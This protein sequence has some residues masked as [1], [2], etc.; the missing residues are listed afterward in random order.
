MTDSKEKIILVTRNFPPLEGGMERLN[1]RLFSAMS[2]QWQMLLI[3]PKNASRFLTED[4]TVSESRVRPLWWFMLS[5][6][7]RCLA[8][9]IRVKP[10]LIVAGSG[11]MAPAA[12]FAAKFSHSKTVVYLHGLDLVVQNRVYQYCW[13][14]LIRRCDHILVNSQSTAKIAIEKGVRADK[15]NL[16]PPGT[17]IPVLSDE[18]AKNFRTSLGLQDAVILLTVGRLT[19]RKGIAEFVGACLPEIVSV[20][21]NAVLLIIG[22][23]ASNALAGSGVNEKN[24]IQLQ[25]N[26][27][28]VADN[29]V[30]LGRCDDEMLSAAYQAADMHVFPVQQLPGDVEGFGMVAV[31]AAAHGLQTV[32]FAVGGV[33]ESVENGTSGDLIATGD[34]DQF[35]KRILSRLAKADSE[36]DSIRC[37][38]F[39]EAYSWNNF[40]RKIIA[41]CN[42]FIEK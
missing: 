7:I 14:P 20:F 39:A 26:K 32:A 4:T 5:S 19:A 12:Y 8:N 37:R 30:F 40:N 33:S 35:T 36:S 17:D 16:L 22:S 13:L 2:E 6:F 15:I 29:V 24:R 34:Y 23:E 41:F 28:G 42:A 27:A 31:E 18:K 25:A 11:L 9:A 10:G 3:G 1:L 38:E 21:P